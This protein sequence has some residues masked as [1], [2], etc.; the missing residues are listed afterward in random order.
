M[1][2]RRRL[3]NQERG[4]HVEVVEE[5]DGVICHDQAIRIDEHLLKGGV[6]PRGHGAAVGS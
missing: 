2:K 6:D 1:S 3:T 5:F 4:H